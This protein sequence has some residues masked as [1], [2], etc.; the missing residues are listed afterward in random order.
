MLFTRKSRREDFMTIS[1]SV[2]KT[3]P[4]CQTPIK[5]GGQV[6]ICSACGMPHHAECWQENHGCTTF[7]CQGAPA[8]TQLAA[9]QPSPQPIPTSTFAC[10]SCGFLMRSFDLACP[11]C[12]NMR[13]QATIA[14]HQTSTQ[15]FTNYIGK[16]LFGRFICVDRVLYNIFKW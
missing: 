4:Y 13:A 14:A 12:D 8:T 6:T 1:S 5:P 16:I 11:V 15:S 2:G 10:P 3:C 9:P 7:G